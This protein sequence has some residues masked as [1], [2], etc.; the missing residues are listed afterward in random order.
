[1]NKRL[2]ARLMQER[3]SGL[4][5]SG[6]YFFRSD[7]EQILTGVVL[8]YTPKGV[9]VWNFRFPLFDFFGPHLTYSDRLREHA[10]IGKG[11]MTEQA[12]VDFVVS[13]PEAK[14]AFGAAAP[15]SLSE[16]VQILE[17]EA[18]LVKNSHARLTHAAALVLLGQEARAADLLDELPPVLHEKDTSNCIRLQESLRQGLEAARALLNQVRQENMRVLGVAS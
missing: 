11:E 16:F 14:G 8:E 7:F 1:M 9:Y 17:S 3:V 10:Y 18:G 2:I 13:S 15:M 12:I 4:Y 5:N 6:A